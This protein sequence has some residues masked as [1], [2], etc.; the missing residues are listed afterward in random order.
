MLS[1][2]DAHG[3]SLLGAV[4]SAASSS[5]T[6]PPSRAPEQSEFP[7]EA[8]PELEPS[9][10]S[11]PAGNKHPLSVVDSEELKRKGHGLSLLA[12]D[13]REPLP[14]TPSAPRTAPKPP[15]FLHALAPRFSALP[16]AH[17][18]ASLSHTHT[19]AALSHHTQACKIATRSRRWT[20]GV[21]SSPARRSARAPGGRRPPPLQPPP[22]KPPEEEPER[23]L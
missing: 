10:P 5:S 1:H 18:R 2:E 9:T 19:I 4:S 17:T 21:S 20:R 13:E 12:T 3:A 22:S 23:S 6:A 7:L 15:F 16:H 11:I 8:T 14:G